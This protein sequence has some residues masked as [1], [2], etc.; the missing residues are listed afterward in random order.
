MWTGCLRWPNQGIF[1]FSLVVV[2]VGAVPAF[3]ILADY[4]DATECR[5][6]KM[7]LQVLVLV[8]ELPTTTTT[9]T[10]CRYIHA[11]RYSSSSSSSSSGI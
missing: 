11:C 8:L 9:T 1:K 3:E 10:T 5:A 6:K 4:I 7:R 2:D